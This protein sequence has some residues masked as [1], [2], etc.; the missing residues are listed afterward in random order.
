MRV[1]VGGIS[2]ETNTFN[3]LPTGLEAFRIQRG[4]DLLEDGAAK[5]L[6][7]SGVDVIP[8]IFARAPPSGL[9]KRNAYIHIKG[10]ST[11]E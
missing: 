4:K 3:P 7:E 11:Q 1:V 10:S 6:M 2:H 9:I 8:T 5:S